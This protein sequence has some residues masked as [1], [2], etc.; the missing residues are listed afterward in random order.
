MAKITTSFSVLSYDNNST[1]VSNNGN[2]STIS[3]TSTET[4]IETSNDTTNETVQGDSTQ[5]ADTIISESAPLMNLP[6]MIFTGFIGLY[7]FKR[8]VIN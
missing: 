8:K 6:L 4:T 1:N 3:E 2:N 5:S 7:I